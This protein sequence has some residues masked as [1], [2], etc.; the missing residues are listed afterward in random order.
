MKIQSATRSHR[1]IL[2]FAALALAVCALAACSHG[3]TPSPPGATSTATAAASGAGSDQAKAGDPAQTDTSGRSDDAANGVTTARKPCD[4]LTRED[5]EAA[6]GQPL[7]KNNVNIEVGTC[8]YTADD[9]SASTHVTVA[10][11][12]QVKK[13]ATTGPHQHVAISGIGDEAFNVVW[14]GLSILYVRRGDEG[15]ALTVSS[16][17]IDALLDHGL[18][19]EKALAL[20]IIGRF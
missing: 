14:S 7:P 17:K 3:S 5:S 10:S 9:L 4:L 6:V 2:G 15:F 11:W 12:E 1:K 18:A 20:K 16:R 13:E 8:D 19:A